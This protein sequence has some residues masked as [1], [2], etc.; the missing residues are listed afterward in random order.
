MGIKFLKQEDKE[1]YI[2]FNKLVF[3]GDRIEE[4]IDKLLFR[5]PFSKIEEDCFYIEENNEIIASLV[6]TKKVQ[7]IGNN[8]VK[9]GEFDLVGTHPEYRHKGYC[10]KLM[11]YS[12]NKMKEDEIFLCRLIGIPDFYQQYRFEY[13][14]P[15]YFYN[16][17]TINHE[18]LKNSINRYAVEMVSE[19]SND[20]LKKMLEIFEQE[21]AFNFGSEVRSVEYLRYMIEEKCLDENSYWYIVIEED[22]LMGYAWIKEEEKQLIIKEAA[23]KNEAASESICFKLYQILIS[24]NYNHLGVRAPLN[25]SFAKY[26]YKHG[27]AMR[28]NNEI[29]DGTWGEMY[30][31]LNLNDA[32]MNISSLLEERLKE[33]KFYKL[34]A[35]YTIVTELES[36]TL[37]IDDGVIKI[38][39]GIGLE[40]KI[41]INVLT[42]VYTGYKSIEC[43]KD[44]IQYFNDDMEAVFKVLFPEGY[45]YIWTLDINDS[46]NEI[47]Y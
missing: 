45:P 39:N 10:S 28:C 3:K 14:V 32:L 15:A 12:F 34:T 7:R 8:I 16:Y 5:N 13:A 20:L 40:V 44:K 24:K 35:R 33:S 23:M 27:G 46:L 21:T 41:P 9:V 42:S 2:K 19:F 43:F 36:A 31:I 26:I 29:F 47:T 4:E 25:N 6:V 37:E 30:R 18:A 17:V 22:E 1:R 38:T 11:E